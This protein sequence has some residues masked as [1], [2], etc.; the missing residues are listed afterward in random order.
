MKK[1]ISLILALLTVVS[2]VMPAVASDVGN[3]QL[4]NPLVYIRGA[5]KNLYRYEN[6]VVS[7]EHTIYPVEIDTD[8]I[9]DALKPITEDLVKGMLTG[10][11]KE[12]VDTVYNVTLE[13][14]YE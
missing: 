7:E 5:G 1:I 10:D 6:G 2:M 13:A 11:Y 8:A 12:Y 4:N 9:V 14:F 3:P